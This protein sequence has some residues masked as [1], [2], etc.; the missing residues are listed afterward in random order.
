MSGL[1]ARPSPVYD[2]IDWAQGS[3]KPN[4]TIAVLEGNLHSQVVPECQD[5]HLKCFAINEAD[6]GDLCAD[7]VIECSGAF[8]T[9]GDVIEFPDGTQIALES[10]RSAP[11]IG[12]SVMTCLSV[13]NHADYSA[14]LSDADSAHNDGI[15]EESLLTP[16]LFVGDLVALYAPECM[17]GSKL[18]WPLYVGEHSNMKV[19]LHG[20]TISSCCM[21]ASAMLS[22]VVDPATL[23]VDVQSRPWLGRYWQAVSTL[24]RLD[25]DGIECKVSGFNASLVDSSGSAISSTDLP[26]V[27]Y[28]ASV[29]FI[30]LSSSKSLY[31]VSEDVAKMVDYEVRR[32]SGHQLESLES[33]F[34]TVPADVL[35]EAFTSIIGRFF[36]GNTN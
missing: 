5:E 35:S 17:I 13:F 30:S 28:A 25:R 31:R 1:S 24:S 21:P 36:S 20:A 23:C 8:S 33:C 18:G 15:F 12:T 14:L 4:Q 32:R 26:I 19:G 34:K 3:V 6:L 7:D 29:Y 10:Y 22:E 2:F 11:F 16:S 9:P 27:V